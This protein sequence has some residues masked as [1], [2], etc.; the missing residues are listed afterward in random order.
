MMN[1]GAPHF[2]QKIKQIRNSSYTLE[3]VINEMI[4]NVLKIASEINITLTINDNRLYEIII[5]DNNIEGFKNINKLGSENPFN[6]GHVSDTHDDDDQTS[7]FGIG[8]KAGAI[9]AGNLLE[10]YSYVDNKYYQIICDFNKMQMEPDVNNS[11]NPILVPI[12]KET[13]NNSHMY[14]YGSTIKISKIR[15]NIYPST[16]E[17]KISHDIIHSIRSTYSLYIKK[18]FK[19]TLNNIL[20]ES[21]NDYFDN[22]KCIPFTIRKYLIILEN[23]N[24]DKIMFV[25]TDTD[26]TIIYMVED[27]SNIQ[28]KKIKSKKDTNENIESKMIKYKKDYTP[29]LIKKSINDIDSLLQDG[30]KYYYPI[31][32]NNYTIIIESTYTRYSD[33]NEILPCDS[34]DIY[35]DDR[36]YGNTPLSKKMDGYHNYNIHRIRFNSKIIGKELGITFNKDINLI[37]CNNNLSETIKKI[38]Q[39]NNEN[40]TS[41]INSQINK[42]LCDIAIHNKFINPLECDINMLSQHHRK[43]YNREKYQEPIE[44]TLEPPDEFSDELQ[45]ES[46]VKQKKVKKKIQ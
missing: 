13:Y 36:K 19:I 45:N 34:V 27:K 15:S 32:D 23:E 8:L 5:S 1:V 42:K 26:K 12:S 11:Y 33:N 44:P 10:V 29:V 16:T 28:D 25:M 21:M 2:K 9:N 7:E 35:R 18:G 46:L 3:K 37:N 43:F 6:M 41:N 22:I 30:Y 39:I 17:D 14:E 20:V 38:L 24:Q 40:I 4:D 31:E